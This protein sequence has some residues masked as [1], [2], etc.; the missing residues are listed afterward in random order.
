MLRRKI[1]ITTALIIGLGFAGPSH[2]VED[3]AHAGHASGELTLSLNAGNKWQGDE[4]MISGMNAIRASLAPRVSAIHAGNL[5]AAEYKALAT[6]IQGQADFMVA[7]CKL[8]PEADEQFHM[9]LGQ[10]LDGVSEMEKGPQPEVGAA[11]IVSALNS[12][13]DYF[14]HPGWQSLE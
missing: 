6:E 4:N 1:I 7:N 8:T 12:Y 5:P 10:V 2:A 14:V 11:R 9:I 3:P 13:G